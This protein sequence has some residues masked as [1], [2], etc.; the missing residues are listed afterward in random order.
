MATVDQ[1]GQNPA[2][3]VD[4]PLASFSRIYK[5]LIIFLLGSY[6]IHLGLGKKKTSSYHVTDQTH[7]SV[8]KKKHDCYS[9]DFGTASLWI[10]H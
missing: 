9:V 2:Y 5:V 3:Q 10:Q 8:F 1:C 4:K 6:D 7:S